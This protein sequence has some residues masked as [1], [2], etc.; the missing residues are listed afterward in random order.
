[1]KIIVFG[2][3]GRTGQEVIEQAI[4]S[5]IEVTA[6][7]RNADNI[8]VKSDKLSIVVGQATKYED[9]KNAMEGHDVVISCIGGD[10]SKVST[11][12][13][14]ITKNIVDAMNETGVKRIAQVA[15]A[16]V[17][18]ELK[19]IMGK[20]VSFMLKNPLKDHAGA[21]SKLKEG[22]VNYT[23]ARPMSLTEGVFTG[24]Y[25][26]AEEGIPDKARNISRADVAHFLLKAIQDDKYIGKSIGLAY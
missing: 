6:F 21:Y 25:R 18:G 15:S 22:G 11:T 24:V 10:G 1:M 13:T 2:A 16:G 3:N 5:G 9:V 19:G 14:D 26:E 8:K 7:V 20:I 4:S 12:I 23:L 17:H